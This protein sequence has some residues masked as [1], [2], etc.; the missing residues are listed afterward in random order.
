MVWAE[1]DPKSTGKCEPYRETSAEIR[2]VIGIV[3]KLLVAW[4][5]L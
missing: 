1:D 2:A 5:T 3:P 4:L